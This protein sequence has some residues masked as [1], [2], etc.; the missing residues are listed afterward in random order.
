MLPPPSVQASFALAAA[1]NNSGASVTVAR[2]VTQISREGG[3]VKLVAEALAEAIGQHNSTTTVSAI[4]QAAAA[5]DTNA[6]SASVAQA[7]KGKLLLGLL[8]S[9]NAYSN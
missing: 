7:S 5:G 8:L 2:A 9:L 4:T 6:I 3:D 1:N